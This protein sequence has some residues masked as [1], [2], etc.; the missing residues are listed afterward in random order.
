MTSVPPN[1]ER[2]PDDAPEPSPQPM[3]GVE[4]RDAILAAMPKEELDA[5]A[6]AIARVWLSATR[7]N[8]REDG[9]AEQPEDVELSPAQK[10]RARAAHA[11]R[12]A[13]EKRERES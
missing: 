1:D 12:L 3:T 6:A 8:R 10:A 13:A 2:V 11:R 7:R 4:R 9:S 5:L